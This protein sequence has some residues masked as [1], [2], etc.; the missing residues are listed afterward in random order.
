MGMAKAALTVLTAAALSATL[1]TLASTQPAAAATASP[2]K[3]ANRTTTSYTPARRVLREGDRGRDVR[4]LQ[5]RLAYLKYYPGK[6]DG[7]FGAGTLEAVWAFQ[8][9]HGLPVTGVVARRTERSLVA[10]GS[11][12]PLIRHGQANRVEISLRRHVLLVWRGHRIALISHVSSGGGYYYCSSGG[13][14]HAITPTGNFRVIRRIHG[15]HRSDLGLMYNPVYFYGGY[16]IHGDTYVPVAPVSHGCVRIP[17][18]VASIFPPLV[19]NGT[20]VY[21]RNL[22]QELAL[23]PGSFCDLRPQLPLLLKRLGNQNTSTMKGGAR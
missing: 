6:V 12:R 5:R 8:E 4:R 15:W 17:M 20:R 18:D 21:V 14:S 11:P 9:V 22:R 23:K 19:R 7:R 13:C 2:H 1:A 16:A 3:P 10:G